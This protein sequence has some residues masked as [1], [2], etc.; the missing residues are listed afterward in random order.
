MGMHL[1]NMIRTVS[2]FVISLVVCAGCMNAAGCDAIKGSV[3]W[4]TGASQSAS[5]DGSELEA[6]TVVK[7]VDGDTLRIR[8]EDGTTEKVRLVGIDA[9]ESV[10]EDESRNCEEGY[11]ASDHMKTLV[12]AGDTVYLQKDTSDTDKYGRLL[13]YV[14]TTVP[15]GSVT[16]DVM[17]SDMLNARMVYDGYAK[18]KVY[19]QDDLYADEL[20]ACMED[21]ASNERG[22]YYYWE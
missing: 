8:H 9:P 21:A 15:T 5:I 16:E 19:G 6:V 13:R 7:V 10:A 11:E 18:A 12:S 22:V 2:V 17:V 4:N 1:R 20:K 14:W 3:P